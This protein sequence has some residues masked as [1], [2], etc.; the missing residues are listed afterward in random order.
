MQND[1]L[2]II[3]KSSFHLNEDLFKVI[4]DIDVGIILCFSD[5]FK[6][7]TNFLNSNKKMSSPVKIIN[8]VVYNQNISVINFLFEKTNTVKISTIVKSAI[9]PLESSGIS[10]DDILMLR[11]S[12]ASDKPLLVI[13]KDEDQL[14]KISPFL[15]YDNYMQNFMKNINSN[16]TTINFEMQASNISAYVKEFLIDSIQIQLAYIFI[17]NELEILLQHNKTNCQRP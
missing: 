14:K 8:S 3:V 10:P 16:Q 15:F 9:S 11:R 4:S 6:E 7:I 12:S 2:Y 17:L 5:T 13:F 1:L